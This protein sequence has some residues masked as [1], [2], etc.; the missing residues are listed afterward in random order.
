MTAHDT[1]PSADMTITAQ[2]LT[3]FCDDYLSASA[4]K[5][6]APNGL[7]IDG[8]QPIRRIVTGVTACEALIDAAI[9][10]DA[11]AIMVH[12]GYFWKG[13]PM[14][15]TGMKGQRIRKLMQ[16]GI[17][18]IGYHLPLDAHPKIGNNAKLAEMLGLTITEALYPHESHPVGNI[19]TC[20][21]QS[22]ESLTQ[23][24]TQAL[25]RIPL[26]ISGHYQYLADEAA[27]TAAPKLLKRIGICTGGAQDMIEQAA[28]MGCDAYI[29]G[30]ISERTTHSARELGI[31]YFACGHHATERA[32]IQALGD[33]VAQQFGLSVRFIDIDNPA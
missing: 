10:E 4:F 20:P 18:L 8:G 31:D 32:G 33:I 12:H 6:Y 21:P 5:D 30:E 17:S 27:D 22:A 16:H 29:S 2:A 23:T 15:I 25:G 14:T 26:H 24:I 3:E 7:Q 9:A 19:A 28:A 11:D 13:E 1:P